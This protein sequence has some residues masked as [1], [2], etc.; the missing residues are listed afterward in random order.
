VRLAVAGA[1]GTAA[2]LLFDHWLDR[3]TPVG[4]YFAGAAFL[5]GAV[6]SSAGVAGAPPVD[7]SEREYTVRAG[8]SYALVG[9]VMIAAGVA[10][11]RFT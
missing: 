1:I 4:F 11:E 7:R 9:A 5:P 8:F 3:P 2:A 10:L 6:V